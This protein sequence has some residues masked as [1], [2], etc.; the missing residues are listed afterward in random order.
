MVVAAGDESVVVE[1][2]RGQN[3]TLFEQGLQQLM[4]YI[5]VA[6]ANHG[7]LFLYSEKSTEYETMINNI[8]DGGTLRV[9][10]PKQS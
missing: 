2:K 1:L 7:I 3:R 8:S 6:H 4:S 10:R 9:I 5:E